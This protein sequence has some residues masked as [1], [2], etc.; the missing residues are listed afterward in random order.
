MITQAVDHPTRPTWR[1][2]QCHVC[3]GYYRTMSNGTVRRCDQAEHIKSQLHQDAAVA[4]EKA[5]VVARKKAWSDPLLL[6]VVATRLRTRHSSMTLARRQWLGDAENALERLKAPSL[7][8]ALLAPTAAALAVAEMR[9][10]AADSHELLELIA[11]R[12]CKTPPERRF[13][14]VAANHDVLA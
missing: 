2:K 6:G 10:I 13:V 5:A 7:Q 3:L 8:Q 4:A 1:A 12:V 14:L 11:T 9:G